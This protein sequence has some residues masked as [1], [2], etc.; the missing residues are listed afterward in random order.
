M[1][2]S[3]IPVLAA[4]LLL[5][6]AAVAEG[7]KEVTLTHDY[8]AAL[9]SSDA[10]TSL[11]M[12][13]LTKA[14]RRTCTSRIPAYGGMYTDLGCAESLVSAAVKDIHAAQA[15]AGTQMAPSF[16]RLALTRLASAD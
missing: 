5:S 9:L 1:F 2:K 6:P 13:E 10:G 11:L 15:A 3:T 12:D 14:A 7:K 16:E 4:V 8:D